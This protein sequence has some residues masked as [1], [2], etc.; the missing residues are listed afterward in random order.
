MIE[1]PGNDQFDADR[2]KSDFPI[3][4]IKMAGKPLV[5]LDSAATSQKPQQVIDTIVRYYS[6]YNANIH[7]GIYE[8]AERATEEYTNSK[9]KLAKLIGAKGVEN[10]VYVRN[11]TEAIN[12]VALSWGNANIGKGDHILI[13]DMEH[14]SNLVPWQLLERR[15]GAALDYIKLDSNNEKLDLE[16]FKENLEKD[17]KIVA[18][19]H[20][21]NVLGTIN[22]VKYIT[23][24]AKKHGSV[25]LIDGAQ[26]A[27]HMPVD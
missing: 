12:L 1:T 5:Y 4:K 22:D 10:I 6:E 7:R 17:P 2:I 20:A 19:T 16:S 3:F 15:K 25:V 24:E 23:R 21:S 8:I 14:H 26:S 9:D 13:S 11:T 27:P 18:I